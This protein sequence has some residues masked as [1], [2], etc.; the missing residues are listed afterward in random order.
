MNPLLILKLG[1]TFPTWS[2]QHGDFED[3]IRTTVQDLVADVVIH[4]PRCRPLPS[5]GE[6]CAAILTGSHSMVT[7][8]LAWSEQVAAWIPMA[9][10][11]GLPLLGICYGHQLI[12]HA[13]GGQVGP[14]PCGREF[15]TVELRLHEAARNDPLFGSLPP[16]ICVQT[17][18]AQ[19]VLRLPPGAVCLG[20]TD[21][22]PHS[23]YVL[24]GSAWGVQFHPE[25]DP[26]TVR[27]YIEQCAQELRSDGLDPATLLAATAATPQAGT[28]LRRF[29]MLCRGSGRSDR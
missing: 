1:D 27:T 25:Y 16:S 6:F 20:A 24:P 10:G 21:R 28:L 12:A 8:R 15:G 2:R 4:D 22:D 29:V 18:H 19:A 13:L 23:A 7:D 26:A 11:V 17:S 3:W 9:N 14:L 5:P